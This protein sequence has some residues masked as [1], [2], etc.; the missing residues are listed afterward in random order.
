MISLNEVYKKYGLIIKKI[1]DFS[2]RNNLGK[3]YLI[4]DHFDSQEMLN[5]Y[6]TKYLQN[7]KLLYQKIEPIFGKLIK[8]LPKQKEILGRVKK[9]EECKKLDLYDLQEVEFSD[10]L[11]CDALEKQEKDFYKNFNELRSEYNEAKKE[12]LEMSKEVDILYVDVLNSKYSILG[13][14]HQDVYK[15]FMGTLELENYTSKYC[16]SYLFYY[17]SFIEDI[18]YRHGSNACNRG[19]DIKEYYSQNKD[20]IDQLRASIEICS[21]ISLENRLDEFVKLDEC[22]NKLSE[23]VGLNAEMSH[24]LGEYHVEDVEPITVSWGSLFLPYA[25]ASIQVALIPYIREFSGL[26]IIHSELD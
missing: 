22:K 12:F 21:K 20:S 5:K 4:I 3:I 16:D 15:F 2:A 26:N 17:L 10:L 24:K 9:L 13:E 11:I 1:E 25:A 7:I 23:Y 18:K 14:L 19:I 8:S 6:D